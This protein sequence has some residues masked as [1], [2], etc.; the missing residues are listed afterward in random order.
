MQLNE[1]SF[2]YEECTITKRE[3]GKPA[4]HSKIIRISN[5]DLYEFVSAKE[6]AIRNKHWPIQ[7]L[8]SFSLY[9]RLTDKN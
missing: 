6:S 3:E 9:Y 8:L 7:N 1:G 4:V 2:A 5:W